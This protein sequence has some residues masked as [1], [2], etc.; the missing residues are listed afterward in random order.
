MHKSIA[1]KVGH[2]AVVLPHGIL[3]RIS[4]EDEIRRKLLKMDCLD[5]V[6][7]LAPNLFY[8]TGL[9]A[10][11]LIEGAP[12]SCIVCRRIQTMQ[13]WPCAKRAAPRAH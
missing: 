7:G 13:N 4:K 11:V 1:Q 8:G 5:V 6:I 3:F 9:A 12:K 2:M 10:Y